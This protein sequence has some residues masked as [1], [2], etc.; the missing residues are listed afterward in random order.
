MKKLLF[1]LLIPYC[2]L[3]QPKTVTLHNLTVV[4][5]SAT[6]AELRAALT[7]TTPPVLPKTKVMASGRFS[8]PTSFTTGTSQTYRWDFTVTTPVTQLQFDFPNW[9]MGQNGGPGEAAGTTALSISA[10]VDTTTLAFSGRLVGT[11]APGATLRNDPSHGSYLP[12]VTYQLYVTVTASRWPIGVFAATSPAVK[13]YG[14]VLAVGTP[15]G[16]VKKKSV[17]IL[18]DSQQIADGIGWIRR[19]LNA[20]GIAHS[21]Y[22]LGSYRASHFLNS[23]GQI[24]LKHVLSSEADVIIC[25]VGSNDLVAAKVSSADA[26]KAL[27]TPI[28]ERIRASGKEFWVPTITPV[29]GMLSIQVLARG[30]LN[31]WIRSKPGGISHVLDIG[32]AAETAKNNNVQRSGWFFNDGVHLNGYGAQQAAN[33]VIR[34]ADFDK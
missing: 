23:S 7:D 15:V 1:L 3:A 8:A 13:G 32:Q 9:A 33:A 27:L 6:T 4:L 34:P 31:D 26:A 19:G 16:A 18:G 21:V 24:A 28:W 5:D 22:A 12:G 17:I 25:A 11:V 20:A 30:I 29:K 2:A 10:R 14:P